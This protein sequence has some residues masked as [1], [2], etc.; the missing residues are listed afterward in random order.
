[1][2]RRVAVEEGKDWDTL[3]PYLLFA[4]REVPQASTGFTPFEL[5]YGREVRGPLDVLR[6]TWEAS[7]KSDESV[8]SYV[9]SMR[10]KLEKMSEL[11]QQNIHTSQ[12]KQ[13]HWYD[14]NARMREFECGDTVLVLLPTST[15]K[16][17][18]RWQGPYTIT[19][20]LGQ[21]T[22]QI[23]MA[24]RRKRKRT[25]H[26]NM[27]KKWSTP[28][29]VANTLEE[30]TVEDDSEEII[31]WKDGDV[32]KELPTLG[33]QLNEDQRAQ[34]TD[35][36]NS[37]PDVMRNHPGQTSM[38]EH[39]IQTGTATPHRLPPYRLPHAYREEV[40][41]ELEEMREQGIIEP[42]S[43]E[44]SSP[45]VIVKKKDGSLRLCV[46]YR[47]LNEVSQVDA[48]PMPRVD[49]IID[50]LGQASFITTIELCRGYWQ[51]PVAAESRPK[52]AFSTP[53]GLFQLPFGLCGAPATFQRMMN[54]LMQGQKHTAAYL[55]DLIIYSTSWDEHLKEIKQV[56]LKLRA[57]GL[58]AKPRKCQF[59]KAQCSYLGHVVGSG[60]V[61]PEQNKVHAI[62][63]F[64]IPQ[65]KKDVR[66]FLGLTGYY[67]HFIPSYSSI[68]AP[69]T[70]LTKK[71]APNSVTWT[72]S[73]E[74][75]FEELKASM[76]RSPVLHS[77]N[78]NKPFLLQTD[79]SDR[80]VGAVLSQ[81][82]SDGDHPVAYFSKKLLPREERYSVIEKECLAVK[83]AVQT[84]RVY[85][86]S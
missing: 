33:D 18:A 13:K 66:V 36:L 29:A 3:L 12:Q 71:C 64:P 5:L 32:T 30:V 15:N 27:L 48:Y 23:D 35:V 38:A 53:I 46:D 60:L 44:W 40:L 84:F 21:V 77:P 8:V 16:L 42:S 86:L 17:L 81:Q 67:H 22:Y 73:C 49:D 34:L 2:L 78:F 65:N 1:M 24:D 51:V 50:Q 55:D 26:V 76:C 37:F 61:Q 39:K 11:A 47:Y 72:D 43:S 10:E 82:N 41:K 75:A 25:F 74:R 7:T 52:T 69:L 31:F 54:Q 28:E 20:R 83:L 68:A 70:D 80:G 56:L 85:L 9:I 6:E 63:Q 14:H 19:Q 62:K 4:F 58:T 45:M 57:A 79:A 59:A